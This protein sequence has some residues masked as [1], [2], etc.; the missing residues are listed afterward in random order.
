[1]SAVNHMTADKIGTALWWARL[2]H[3]IEQAHH[4]VCAQVSALD[5]E[6]ARMKREGI[7]GWG[8]L[9][10]WADRFYHMEKNIEH[11]IEY[12]DDRREEEHKKE[13]A[14]AGLPSR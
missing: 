4:H 8:E 3:D 6:V 11:F 12:T 9:Q 2:D 5:R 7:D 13:R 10:A 1:M 14:A